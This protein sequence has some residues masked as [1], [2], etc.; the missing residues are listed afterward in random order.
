MRFVLPL[1][2][3]VAAC[4][5]ASEPPRTPTRASAAGPGVQPNPLESFCGGS[6]T[7][8]CPTLAEHLAEIRTKDCPNVATSHNRFV[9]FACGAFTRVD[10]DYG[11]VG[12][13]RW[14]DGKGTLVGAVAH[15]YEHQTE[16]VHGQ[17]PSCEPA[18]ASPV[19]GPGSP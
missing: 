10:S 7:P 9:M 18:P 2:V 6:T 12:Y 4:S 14:F 3:T 5:H 11:I 1:V 19:C 8:R 15:V 16:A 17:I 13:S